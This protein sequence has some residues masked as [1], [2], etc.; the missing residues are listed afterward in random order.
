MFSSELTIPIDQGQHHE[1]VRL[2]VVTIRFF[3][4]MGQELDDTTNAKIQVLRHLENHNNIVTPPAN[5]GRMIAVIWTRKTAIKWMLFL[6]LMK[7]GKP[8]PPLQHK[9]STNLLTLHRLTQ[10]AY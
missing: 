6:T 2:Y 7:E 3:L 10:S 4:Y 5:M 8:R 9:F 1:W